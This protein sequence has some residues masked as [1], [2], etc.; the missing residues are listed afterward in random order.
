MTERRPETLA[1]DKSACAKRQIPCWICIQL[2]GEH[3]GVCE[4]KSAMFLLFLLLEHRHVTRV[5][6]PCL[7]PRIQCPALD[8]T[9]AKML[10]ILAIPVMSGGIARRL[11]LV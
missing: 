11:L 3:T 1:V 5:P 4:M 2:E 9:S 8:P 6:M 7:Q 10:N